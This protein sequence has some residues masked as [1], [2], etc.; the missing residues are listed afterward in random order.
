MRNIDPSAQHTQGEA[1][2]VC[3]GFRGSSDQGSS[4]GWGLLKQAGPQSPS[5]PSSDDNVSIGGC[6]IYE[7][8]KKTFK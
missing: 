2:H 8:L 6:S 7:C 3:A 1:E 5:A 4:T